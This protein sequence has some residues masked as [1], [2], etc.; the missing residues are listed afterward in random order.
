MGTEIIV[1]I[2]IFVLLVLSA[3]FSGSE[4]ALT[5]ASRARIHTLEQQGD[6][7]AA[8]VS[9]LWQRRERMIGALL[10]GNNL[11]NIT[12]STLS[13]SLFITWFGDT[14][15]VY[16]TIAMTVL[17]VIFS[18][19]LPKTYAIHHA[20]KVALLV[21]KPMRGLVTVLGPLTG[22]IN[23]V[24]GGTFA[25][26]RARIAH[27]EAEREERA[28]EE[29]RGAIDLHAG[30]DEPKE[31]AMLRSILDLAEVEVSE[32]MTPRRD[33]VALD[34]NLPAEEIMRQVLDS[35][36]T[37]FPLWRDNPDNI[38]GILHAKR[39]LRALQATGGETGPLDVLSI[40]QT[41]WFI[42]DTTDLLSQLH[43][44]QLRK[45]H[46]ALVVDEY[47]VFLG[48]VTLEDILEE[49]VGDISDEH[50]E[51]IEGVKQEP[52]GT[53]VIDG[54]VTLRDLNRQFDWRLPD[55][56]ASTIAGLVLFEARTIPEVAQVFE[57]HGF[58]F[59]I[60]GRQRHQITKL[61]VTPPAAS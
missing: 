53:F 11:V 39:L 13:A 18:E 40:A 30:Q 45:E 51:E 17:V 2:A 29:L 41:A 37:R 43:A 49:I 44:F 5:G 56:E 24:V 23:A 21:A 10:I 54:R 52:D 48:I 12:A 16:A 42:P 36:F 46:F 38:V 7:R 9:D 15:I 55:E 28:E 59:E 50:D 60:L 6:S 22:M 14:G 3:C 32:I 61:R 58:R 57:F 25:L 27:T 1:L 20:D 8:V 19:V 47:G 26:F 33:V 34:A 35:P 4:T 31:K